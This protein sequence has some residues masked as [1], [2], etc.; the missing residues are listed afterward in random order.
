HRLLPRQD[1]SLQGAEVRGVQTR[2]PEEPGRQSAAPRATRRGTPPPSV[3]NA[4]PISVELTDAAFGGE[5]IGHLPDGRVVF[6]PRTLPG[7]AGLISVGESRRDFA[8]GELVELVRS[9]AGRV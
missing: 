6:V 5:A 4:S 7:E 8:R 3:L 2:A 1:G 9:A